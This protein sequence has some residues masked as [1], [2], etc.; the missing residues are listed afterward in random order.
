MVYCVWSDVGVLILPSRG[1]V[2]SPAVSTADRELSIL[3]FGGCFSS[4]RDA[5]LARRWHRFVSRR[6]CLDAPSVRPPG[7][8]VPDDSES[9]RSLPTVLRAS[10][11]ERPDRTAVVGDALSLSYAE[12]DQCVDALAARLVREGAEPGDRIGLSVDRGPLPLVGSA[13]IQRAG[14]LYVPLDARHPRARLEHIATHSRLAATVCDELGASVAEQCGLARISVDGDDLV[15]RPST[16]SLEI[17]NPTGAAYIMYTSGS[18]GTPKG[19][20]VTQAN[21]M[22]LLDDA[23]HLFG[24]AG[25]EVWPLQHA[26]GFD[27]SV[28]EMWAGI[29]VGATLIASSGL[30]EIDQLAEEMLRHRATRLHIV[31][32]VFGH[33]A[34]LVSDEEAQLPLRQVVFC[35]E[36]VNWQAM[37]LWTAS[38]SSRAPE[39]VNVYGVT[40]TAVYN[41]HKVLTEDDILGHGA[42]TPIGSAY[43]TSPALVVGDDLTPLP[44][45]QSGEILIGGRQVARGYYGDPERTAQ[46]LVSLP[47]RPGRWY[48]TGDLGS[49]DDRGLLH[50]AGRMDDQV[51]VR[52]FR[53]ELGEIDHAVL[54]LALDPR[55]RDGGAELQT[56]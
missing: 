28:W 7:A 41:T 54:K 50:H 23:L 9:R 32:S 38:Q 20:E 44:A 19:V 49:A 15:P 37:S 8:S 33:L 3:R 34:E 48:R 5:Y 24:Y 1:V 6:A 2:S 22:A 51:K 29:A 31:P 25:D 40:E 36:A 43:Q 47:D 12:L 30:G 46:R 16:P 14:C 10:A 56:G 17:D 18:T 27:V 45:G 53:I 21:V 11:R 13:A 4:A 35:G 52:G 26:Y 39:W 42:T 55:I